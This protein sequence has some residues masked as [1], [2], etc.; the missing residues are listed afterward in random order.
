VESA[1]AWALIIKLHLV[2]DFFLER[3]RFSPIYLRFLAEHD[4]ANERIGAVR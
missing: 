2:S 1:T 4:C 3:Q